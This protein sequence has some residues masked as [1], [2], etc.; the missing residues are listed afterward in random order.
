MFFVLCPC[1]E[2][3]VEVPSDATDPQREQLWNVI[4]CET[5]DAAFDYDDDDVQPV[6]DQPA[7]FVA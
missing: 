6:D 2:S 4:V 3:R 1:C 7:E 5:C